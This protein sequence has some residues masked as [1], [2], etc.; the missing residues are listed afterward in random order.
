M[1]LTSDHHYHISIVITISLPVRKKLNYHAT[2]AD[3]AMCC[4]NLGLS[5][6]SFY[7][8]LKASR[9]IDKYWQSCVQER[10]RQF[11]LC[12]REEKISVKWQELNT[13]CLLSAS[14]RLFAIRRIHLTYSDQSSA[15]LWWQFHC[16]SWRNWITMSLVQICC[17]NLGWAG[18][19][20]PLP[21]LYT[22]K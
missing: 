8:L 14:K 18:F 19:L 4:N 10:D 9:T 15:L 6:G 21:P 11:L 12:T 22:S 20:S 2:C 13:S 7:L 17:K 16:L 1:Q 5:T 3:G